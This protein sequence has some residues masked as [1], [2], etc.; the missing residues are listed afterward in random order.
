MS[1]RT[2]ERCKRLQ[3]TVASYDG[4]IT[5]PRT[6]AFGLWPVL[7]T[8]RKDFRFRMSLAGAPETGADSLG[9]TAKPRGMEPETP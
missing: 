8:F 6:R 3:A 5:R 1:N 2:E 7:R 4:G 9:I